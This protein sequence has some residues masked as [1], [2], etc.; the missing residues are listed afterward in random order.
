MATHFS[1]LTQI[2]PW[3]QEPGGL[4]SKGSQGV[5]HIC[6]T[7]H[8]HIHETKMPCTMRHDKKNLT[9][10]YKNFD[11]N[12]SFQFSAQSCPT[13]CD[14]VYIVLI[15]IFSSQH[16]VALI[17]L[18]INCLLGRHA[19]WNILFFNSVLCPKVDIVVSSSSLK[20]THSSGPIRA[21]V[22]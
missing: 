14:N 11:Q 9:S 1:I 3:T 15:F 2:I 18:F 4:Q 5:R 17:S 12:V 10:V 16:F 22:S 20:G 21:N 8:T 13:L 6:V 7:K 19:R